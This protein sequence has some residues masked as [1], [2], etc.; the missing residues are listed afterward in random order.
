MGEKGGV[1]R[2]VPNITANS[3]FR[4]FDNFWEMWSYSRSGVLA[5]Y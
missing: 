1:L 2:V 5:I 3:K 4:A